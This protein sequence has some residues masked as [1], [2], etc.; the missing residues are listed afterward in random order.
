MTIAHAQRCARKQ[1]FWRAK[2]ILPE[3]YS[4]LGGL[5]VGAPGK[6]LKF[7]HPRYHFLSAE[8]VAFAAE[9]TVRAQSLF[10][11]KNCSNASMEIAQNVHDSQNSVGSCPL[12]PL[13]GMHMTMQDTYIGPAVVANIGHYK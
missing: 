8:A 1:N 7:L 9:L 10:C 6:I 13:P 3:K 12:A 4:S 2:T 5:G 11:A